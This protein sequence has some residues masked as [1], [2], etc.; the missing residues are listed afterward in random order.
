[1]KYPDLNS[2]NSYLFTLKR[3]K[4]FWVF[5]LFGSFSSDEPVIRDAVRPRLVDPD[6]VSTEPDIPNIVSPE[7]VIPDFI[8][9]DARTR[10]ETN[11]ANFFTITETPVQTTTAK[12]TTNRFQPQRLQQLRTR[13]IPRRIKKSEPNSF[14][15]LTISLH[16][17]FVTFAF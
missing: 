12:T 16:I 4:Y 5:D 2:A 9:A 17:L 7:P 11:S 15:C 6:L 3:R 8:R 1:M 10:P 13:P 14:A